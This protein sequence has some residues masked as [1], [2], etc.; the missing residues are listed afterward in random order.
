MEKFLCKYCDKQES[1]F[2]TRMVGAEKYQIWNAELY[3]K[4]ISP[5]FVCFTTE[6]ASD[7]NLAKNRGECSL[8]GSNCHQ[9]VNQ[10]SQLSG[11]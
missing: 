7:L 11:R 5:K 8:I 9:F 2:Q 3:A 6:F 4:K 10:A 1:N